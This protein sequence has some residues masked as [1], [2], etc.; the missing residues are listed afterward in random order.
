M[1]KKPFKKASIF[2]ALA[3]LGLLLT[4]VLAA[5]G[6]PTATTAPA[7]T[8]A[9]TAAATTAAGGTT[10]AATTAAAQTTSG[11][12]VKF[13]GVIKFGA[14]LSLTGSLNNESKQ[15]Q[16]GYELWKEY[17]NNA[18]G[19]KVAGKSYSVEIIYYDD[20]SKQDKSAQLAERLIKEDK[21]N[22]LLGP[23]GTN[24]T[25]TT[26]AIAE[27][28]KMPMVEGNGAAESIFSQ[29]YKYTFGV[30]SPSANYL[31]GVVDGIAAQNPKPKTVAILSANDNF[32][33]EVADAAKK[34]VEKA[35]M[36]VVLYDKY[37]DKETNLTSQVSKVKESNA[38]VILNSGHLNE[39]IALVKA[40][41]ELKYNPVA[42]GFSVGPG[43]PEFGENLKADAN[44]VLGGSQ[45]TPA[46][47]YEGRDLFGSAQKYYDAYK[48]KFNIEPAYQAA[49]GTAC[50]I[51]FQFALE[52]AGTLDA[53][54]VRDTL[55]GLDVMSF[56]GQIKFDERG[57]NMTKPMVVE[58]WQN[59]KRVT[60]FPSEVAEAKLLFPTPTWDK[61]G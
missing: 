43:L 16:N 17:V 20:E 42:M 21:V 48:K 4:L 2:S 8:A 47:K 39:A 19:I 12:A 50:G 22:F 37:P 36:Q 61:R 15:T 10:A 11:G 26:A 54:K 18:G 46:V 59:G 28:Y 44:Y 13:D 38:E 9:T 3:I 55:A 5:C 32:S 56:Y 6:D 34:H 27:Q 60:V 30:L 45:W 29:G 40:M 24:S 51:A 33:V 53:A 57:A 1:V 23:Y 7:T 35:G 14:P 25:K 41:K 58:Q 52:K 31:K 49:S